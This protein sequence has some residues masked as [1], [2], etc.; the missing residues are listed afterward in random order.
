VQI[1][2]VLRRTGVR[3]GRMRIIGFSLPRAAGRHFSLGV[4]PLSFQWHRSRF[5]AS[6]PLPRCTPHTRY[7]SRRYGSQWYVRTKSHIF[8]GTYDTLRYN[9]CP[10]NR[11]R[12]LRITLWKLLGRHTL[13][14]RRAIL[15]R[16]G[17][18][19]VHAGREIAPHRL[20]TAHA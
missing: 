7:K 20:P 12:S 10:S 1:R 8:R 6:A 3:R 9:S 16:I 15:A 19:E 2:S 11:A 5:K 13:G 17:C 14:N 18:G 4:K